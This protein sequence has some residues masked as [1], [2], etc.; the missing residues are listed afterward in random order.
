MHLYSPL[1]YIIDSNILI[2]IVTNKWKQSHTDK[3]KSFSRIKVDNAI[4]INRKSLGRKKPFKRKKSM[5]V[6]II[7]ERNA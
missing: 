1:N 7:S 2:I 4:D 6:L 5:K 3:T